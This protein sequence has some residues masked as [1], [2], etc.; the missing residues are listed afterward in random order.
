MLLLF[1]VEPNFGLFFWVFNAV[2]F[3]TRFVVCS[4]VCVQAIYEY[5]PTRM[6]FRNKIAL[7]GD[8]AHVA[9]PHVGR[10]TFAAM[11][12]S[13]ALVRHLLVASE[14]T[15]S[16]TTSAKST[17][18]TSAAT[19]TSK[20]K[21]TKTKVEIVASALEAFEKE[22]LPPMQAFVN[23]GAAH[24]RKIMGQYSR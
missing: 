5:H 20:A 1:V 24:G 6:V 17:L 9:R 13:L 15:A 21:T 11:E 19:T 16:T 2:R 8:A 18:T 7:V 12:D 22:R 23:L 14:A 4:P 10:G 3:F